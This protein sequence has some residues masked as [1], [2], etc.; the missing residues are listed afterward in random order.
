MIICNRSRA[1]AKARAKG[2]S[3]IRKKGGA[4]ATD[5]SYVEEQLA[6][7]SF[8]FIRYSGPKSVPVLEHSSSS[9]PI[10]GSSHSSLSLS[11]PPSSTRASEESIDA[12]SHSSS[13]LS[14]SPSPTCT[15]QEDA[16]SQPCPRPTLTP[17]EQSCSLSSDSITPNVFS[18]LTTLLELQPGSGLSGGLDYNAPP[19]PDMST[20]SSHDVTPLNLVLENMSEK[21]P[22]AP[23]LVADP[24]LDQDFDSCGISNFW[25]ELSLSGD[26]NFNSDI[27]FTDIDF[28][29]FLVAPQL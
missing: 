28:S 24:L 3:F 25:D 13:S 9:P 15:S 14:P 4:N 20:S 29:S 21:Y 19:V 23:Q 5:I 17:D 7:D 27:E 2:L 10:D 8:T 6:E 26:F 11:P 1:A 16:P 12:F 18:D 22:S